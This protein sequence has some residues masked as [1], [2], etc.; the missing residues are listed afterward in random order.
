MLAEIYAAL[1][2]E[3]YTLVAIGIRTVIDVLASKTVGDVGGFNQKLDALERDGWLSRLDKKRIQIV[4]DAGSAAA[5]RG[6][7]ASPS[8]VEHMLDSVEHLL[9]SRYVLDTQAKALKRAI[10]KRRP[11]RKPASKS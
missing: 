7:R 9:R 4:V 6:F 5:H 2:I 10:P 11:K 8:D 3:A 1:D